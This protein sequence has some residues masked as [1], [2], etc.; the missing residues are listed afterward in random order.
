MISAGKSD[1][2]CND[3]L[4]LTA[5]RANAMYFIRHRNST[6]STPPR[7]RHWSAW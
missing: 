2:Y 6:C 3:Q 7:Y 5:V 4:H 1:E